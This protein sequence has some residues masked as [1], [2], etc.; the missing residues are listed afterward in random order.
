MQMKYSKF[1]KTI[2]SIIFLMVSYLHCYS[3][4]E[5]HG[6]IEEDQEEN[7]KIIGFSLHSGLYK[8]NADIDGSGL[9]LGARIHIPVNAILS[10][11]VNYF[12]SFSMGLS[13][14]PWTHSNQG[15]GLVENQYEPYRDNAQG[16]FPS[17]KFRQST[18]ELEGLLNLVPLLNKTANF[19]LSG[20][21]VYILG[22]YG[23]FGHRVDLDLLDESGKPYE[24][25]VSLS[26]WTI[27][28]FNFDSGRKEI[29]NKLIGYY[30]GVY[31]T[32]MNTAIRNK[33]YSYGAGLKYHVSPSFSIGLEYKNAN[34][35]DFDYIDGVRF[36]NPSELS[37]D[38]DFANYMNVFI[39]G[40]L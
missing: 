26:G 17:Y 30:D 22:S 24:N 28:K 25:L 12:N 21:D 18:I 13:S 6:E 14:Q 4:S 19:N 31:E 2:F 11:R 15:G 40:K 39:E 7:K 37:L 23:F 38:N 8:V 9:G 32:Q 27:E 34:Y 20:F 1:M 33:T 3:Q 5:S 29:K 35:K 36:K 16:W 10:L